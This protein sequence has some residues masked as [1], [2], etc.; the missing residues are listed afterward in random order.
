MLKVEC[1]PLL[2]AS[3]T[4]LVSCNNP[5]YSLWVWSPEKRTDR[6]SYPLANTSNLTF[7]H[8]RG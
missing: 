5:N 2:A 1:L 6:L 7:V 3:V 8:T 4:T